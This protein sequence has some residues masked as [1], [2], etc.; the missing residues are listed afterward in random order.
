MLHILQDA[1][2]SYFSY[3]ELEPQTDYS[4]KI[5]NLHKIADSIDN[6]LLQ[7][8]QLWTGPKCEQTRIELIVRQTIGVA[9]KSQRSAIYI[10]QVMALDDEA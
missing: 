7:T 6:F 4:G 2:P 10:E 8:H 9:L 1:E 3:V 5:A